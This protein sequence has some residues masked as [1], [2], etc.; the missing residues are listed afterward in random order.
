IKKAQADTGNKNGR[1]GHKSND[2]ARLFENRA[3]DDPLVSTEEPFNVG[4]RGRVYVKDISLNMPDLID[5]QVVRGMKAVI[6]RSSKTEGGI[7]PVNVELGQ[8]AIAAEQVCQ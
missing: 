4:E 8:L 2:M 1:H 3:H 7:G 6:H 5:T